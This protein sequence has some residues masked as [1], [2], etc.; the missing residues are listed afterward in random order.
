[1][2]ISDTQFDTKPLASMNDI[3]L[4]PGCKMPPSLPADPEAITDTTYST[5]KFKLSLL[6]RKIM[7]S[8]F[9]LTP[10]SYDQITKLDADLRATYDTFPTGIKYDSLRAAGGPRSGN[11]TLCVQALGLKVILNHSLVIL[12]RPFLYRSFRDARYVGSL[13]KC[14]EA[15]HQVLELFH[16]YRRNVEFI[17]YSWYAM[18]ALHAFHAGTVVGLR[19]Y[20]EPLTC[21]E[22]D[23]RAVEN[24]CREFDKIAKVDGWN[25]LGEKGSKVFGILLRK[26][27]EKK[28]ILEGGLGSNGI[29]IGATGQGGF[30]NNGALGGGGA[31][32]F[33]AGLGMPTYSVDT[34]S[35]GSTA[36]AY[37]P[38]SLF[39]APGHFDPNPLTNPALQSG[40]YSPSRLM[41]AGMPGVVASDSSPDQANWDA[42]WPKGMNL[43]Y[44][45]S[46]CTSNSR[47]SGTCS[48][49][50]WMSISQRIRLGVLGI[51]I[52]RSRME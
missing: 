15:A 52:L 19:C 29:T 44:H 47:R 16:E 5:C 25:K 24:A 48:L 34:G 11:V 2:M 31:G 4:R 26:A 51:R 42:F 45:N 20:L 10:A 36:Y 50:I 14:L 39:G 1:M 43:V 9:G 27:L 22:R 18:G 21:D 35:S 17:E 40:D 8:L 33:D 41:G 6:V 32:G 23:W 12:H 49:R 46:R 30:D 13:E 38:Q 7:S 28:A 37:T 3:D